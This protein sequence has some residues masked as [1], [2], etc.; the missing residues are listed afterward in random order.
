MRSIVEPEDVVYANTFFEKI[1][2][3]LIYNIEELLIPSQIE[4]IKFKQ[5]ISY[6]VSIYKKLLAENK[7]VLKDGW[8]NR[9][10]MIDLLQ[11][12][13]DNCSMIT[14]SKRL[15]RIETMD[16]EETNKTKWFI[17][18]QVGHNLYNKLLREE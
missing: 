2:K 14:A 11:E 9:K 12:K 7:H 15:K 16:E 18:K 13:W 10:E 8:V 6:A 1:W 4:K 17:T 5:T 3:S